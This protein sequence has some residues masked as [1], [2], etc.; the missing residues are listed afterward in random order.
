ME[1]E[2]QALTLNDD[3][4]L[5]RVHG[6]WLIASSERPIS[7]AIAASGRSAGYRRRSW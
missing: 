5:E 1:P 4:L 2:L 7:C 6:A 3:E